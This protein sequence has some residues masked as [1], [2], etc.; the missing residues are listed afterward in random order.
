MRFNSRHGLLACRWSG[1]VLGLLASTGCLEP[2][3]SDQIPPEDVFGAVDA[4]PLE[5]DLEDD[6]I[7][8]ALADPF[9]DEI[10]YLQGYAAGEKVWYWNVPGPT[11]RFIAPVFIVQKADGTFDDT[12]IIDVI[13]GQIGYTPWWRR[14]IVKTTSKYKD[15][16]IWSRAAVDEGVRLGILEAPV[17]TE[18]VFDCPVVR[19]E[20]RVELGLGKTATPT[21]VWFNKK[22][23]YWVAFEREVDVPVTEREIPALPVYILRRINQGAPLYEFATGVDLNGDAKLNASNNVFARPVT[24]DDYTPLWYAAFVLTAPELRSVDSP[25]TAPGFDLRS[26]ESILAAPSTQVVPPI[27]EEEDT[28]VNCP[29]QGRA[30][31]L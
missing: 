18:G 11:P 28:L 17:A 12:P 23:V 2:L 5:Q 6:P 16:R 15:E 20:T 25:T 8:R 3:A 22:R 19:R 13:P 26:E 21:P 9:P 10:A 24:A 29:I 14:V 31:E 27:Q 7:L 30:G 4:E 1:P